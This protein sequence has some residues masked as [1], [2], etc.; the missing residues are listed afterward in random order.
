MSVATSAE[1]F[2]TSSGQPV[3]TPLKDVRTISRQMVGHFID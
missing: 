1:P 2:L 3:S